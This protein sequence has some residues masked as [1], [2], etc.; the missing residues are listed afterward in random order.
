MLCGSLAIS[1]V[2]SID[3]TAPITNINI[4]PGLTTPAQASQEV[5]LKANL[6]SGPLVES[7]SP[8]YEVNTG[9]TGSAA[10]DASGNAITSGDVGV[11]F[12]ELGEA[13][14]LQT[15]QGI[16]ASFISSVSSST[17]AVPGSDSGTALA[18]DDAQTMVFTLDDGSTET[19]SFTLLA[20]NTAAQNAALQVGAINASTGTTGIVATV[21]AGNTIDLTNA[22]STVT[23]SHNI[24]IASV[25][26]TVYIP[27]ISPV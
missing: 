19:V 5:V 18:A 24:A 3:S 27:S 7:F 9:T 8:A 11:M 14:S 26:T 17:N 20:A 16:W 2:R 23:A 1:C 22:N 10:L 15:G 25:T 21:G 12:N 4:A 6:N 13:F